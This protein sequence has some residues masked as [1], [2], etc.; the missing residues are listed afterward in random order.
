MHTVTDKHTGLLHFLCWLT[1]LQQNDVSD[2]WLV[3]CLYKG[4]MKRSQRLT[5][6]STETFWNMLKRQMLGKE[7]CQTLGHVTDSAFDQENF[8]E[9]LCFVPP[10]AEGATA[11]QVPPVFVC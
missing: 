1:D 7:T 8:P 2:G 3:V 11:S 9:N 10:Q 6:D 5:K 4:E